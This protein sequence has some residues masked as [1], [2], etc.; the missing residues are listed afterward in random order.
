MKSMK[1][2]KKQ[3][4]AGFTLI[5]LMI[6]VAIIGI[7]AAVAIPA[8]S[9]YTVKAKVANALGAVD[10]LKTAVALCA[11]EAGGTLTTC[12]DGAAGIPT[13]TATKEVATATVTGGTILMTFATGVGK[14]VDS[15][16]VTFVPVIAAG[17]TNVRWTATASTANTAAKAAIEKN[18]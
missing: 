8:Y 9:D 14:D 1:M 7:L 5:E 4:Q 13:F 12:S 18:N 15:S 11:Q 3:A 16:T 2:L 6:V 10:S 17:G